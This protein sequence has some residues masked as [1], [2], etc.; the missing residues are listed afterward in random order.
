MCVCMCVCVCVCVCMKVCE[1]VSER[2][3]SCTVHK[4]HTVTKLYYIPS[5]IRDCSHS[6][7]KEYPLSIFAITSW[8]LVDTFL[9]LRSPCSKIKLHA[10]KYL[11]VHLIDGVS[12]GAGL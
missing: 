7:K 12:V 10:V 5:S 4:L 6:V 3:F 11:K 8:S 9:W 1:S 2:K